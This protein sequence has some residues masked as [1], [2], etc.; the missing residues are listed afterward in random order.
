[1][2]EGER[3]AKGK[4]EVQEAKALHIP[5]LN[6]W[7]WAYWPGTVQYHNIICYLKWIERGSWKKKGKTKTCI[8]YIYIYIYIYY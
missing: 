6:C 8:L 2:S 1:M 7:G 5:L 4:L 3:G